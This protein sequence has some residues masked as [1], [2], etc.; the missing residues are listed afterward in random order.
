MR[1]IDPID[2]PIPRSW[3][4]GLPPAS[5]KTSCAIGVDVRPGS[6]DCGIGF[7]NRSKPDQPVAK[8]VFYG[9]V[10]DEKDV[11]FLCN[12]YPVKCGVVDCRPESTIVT[13]M[14]EKLRRQHKQFWKAQ[15]APNTSSGIEIQINEKEKLVTLHR[16]MALDRVFYAASNGLGLAIPQN[17]REICSGQFA[18]ELCTST[19]VPV[20]E[21]GAESINW[22]AGADHAHHCLAYMMVAMEIG[23]RSMGDS[24]AITTIRGS[25]AGSLADNSD[26]DDDRFVDPLSMGEATERDDGSVFWDSDVGF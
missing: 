12:Q 3:G 6:W 20:I 2:L 10:R 17:F 14:I 8:L 21:R 1:L 24:T 16:T 5:V 13:R 23:K 15:Y 4:M 22:T 9:K 11:I 19:R 18:S 25:V 26:G 7:M